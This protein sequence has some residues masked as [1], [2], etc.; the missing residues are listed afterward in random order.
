VQEQTPTPGDNKTAAK[1]P[2]NADT[3]GNDT[4]PPKATT[5]EVIK[6][7]LPFEKWRESF[8]ATPENRPVGIRPGEG[9]I[10]RV[11]KALTGQRPKP[12]A[13]EPEAENNEPENKAPAA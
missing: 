6:P 10:S 5:P 11:V 9:P 3:L 1:D 8:K 2:V 13:T 7:S 12:A 4:T